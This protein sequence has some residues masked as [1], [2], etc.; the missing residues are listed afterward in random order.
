MNSTTVV[1]FVKKPTALSQVACSCN[2]FESFDYFSTEVLY[3]QSL[4]AM[5]SF[6]SI[7][8]EKKNS[9]HAAS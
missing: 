2:V 5:S 7:V 8:L 4:M 1:H 6:I 3:M 9:E